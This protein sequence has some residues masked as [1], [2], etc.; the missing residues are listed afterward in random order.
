MEQS[1]PKPKR[2]MTPELLEKL[3]QARKKALEKKKL[4]KELSDKEKVIR[5]AE[6]QARVQRVQQFEKGTPK[7]Q[8]PQEPAAN[9]QQQVEE[10][11]DAE[12]VVEVIR[13]TKKRNTK[14]PPKPKVQKVVKRI[15]E[16]DSSSSDSEDEID[17]KSLLKLKYKTKY[18]NKYQAKP[19]GHIEPEETLQNL[20]REAAADIIRGKVD[21]EVRRLAYSTLFGGH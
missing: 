12:P 2:T 11:I 7:E 19:S 18:Q 4:L 20:P 16:I 5:E 8:E 9:K 15:V 1:E 10:G 17:Y 14:A 21:E 13:T 3:A 6:L